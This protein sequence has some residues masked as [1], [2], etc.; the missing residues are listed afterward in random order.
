M[1][2]RIQEN[3]QIHPPEPPA[4]RAANPSE[5]SFSAALKQ[6]TSVQGGQDVGGL[7]GMW[8]IFAAERAGVAIAPP[9]AQPEP[10]STDTPFVPQFLTDVKVINA[11]TG[12]SQAL[13]PA[14]FAT[15][16]TAQYIADKFGTGK[17]IEQPYAGPAGPYGATATEYYIQVPNGRTV[18]AG[19]LADYYQRMPESQFPGLADLMIRDAIGQLP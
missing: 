9:A 17:V 18:N 2:S 14:Y 19:L 3:P 11:Y 15:R 13:N 16:D 10:P 6:E 5:E 7:E 12:E 4:S 8:Q 1:F